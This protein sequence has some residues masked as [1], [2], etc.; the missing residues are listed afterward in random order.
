MVWGKV[1]FH[2]SNFV[3]ERYGTPQVIRETSYDWKKIS[4]SNEVGI[5]YFT[6]V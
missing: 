3:G 1:A 6:K 2:D 5:A 4:H